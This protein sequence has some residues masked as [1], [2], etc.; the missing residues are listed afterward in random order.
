MWG[1]FNSLT[2]L[3]SEQAGSV[4]KEAGLDATLVSSCW[5]SF[6]CDSIGLSIVFPVRWSVHV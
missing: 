6:R 3:V 2:K 4:I 5:L 1:Q